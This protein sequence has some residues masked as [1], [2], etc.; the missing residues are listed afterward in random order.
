MISEFEFNTFLYCSKLTKLNGS[1]YNNDPSQ[2]LIYK[3]LKDLN[4]KILKAQVKDLNKDFIK[5]VK[6]NLKLY[7]P[8]L[9][10]I[11]DVQYI[12]NWCVDLY[13]KFFNLFPVQTYTPL[14]I[15]FEPLH[16][17]K[18]FSLR[19]MVHI[20]MFENGLKPKIH[21][22]N[23]YPFTDEHLKQNDFLCS[24]KI[25]YFKEIYSNIHPKLSVKVH[26]LAV[27]PASFRNKSQRN[28]LFKHFSNGRIRKIDALKLNEAIKYYN[29]QKTKY[30]PVPF[31]KDYSCMKRKE[32]QNG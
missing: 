21:L 28:Y 2:N 25:K 31:C 7:Y 13:N 6:S 29:F 19:Y 32:C 4:L 3:S 15:N 16:N 11:D 27:S 5:I 8:E 1:I 12:L 23:F 10:S 14:A 20:V 18:D 9:K 26:Y 24:S 17:L 30:I 22:L